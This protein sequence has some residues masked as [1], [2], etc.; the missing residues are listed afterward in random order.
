[1]QRRARKQVVLLEKIIASLNNAIHNNTSES[2]LFLKDEK[3]TPLALMIKLSQ[4]L[5]KWHEAEIA[6]LKHQPDSSDNPTAFA[7]DEKHLEIAKSYFNKLHGD[8]I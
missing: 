6:M 3:E 7:L 1:M 5:L 8:A 4:M 2:L